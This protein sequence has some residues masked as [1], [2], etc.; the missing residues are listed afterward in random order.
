MSL[1]GLYPFG[2]GAEIGHIGAYGERE[3]TIALEAVLEAQRHLE[4]NGE[5]T[6]IT[7]KMDEYISCLLYTSYGY[8]SCV[9]I[10]YSVSSGISRKAVFSK[11]D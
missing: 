1:W 8:R 11:M 2:G 10:Y 7:R 6:I 3:S 9:R 4:R 5:K